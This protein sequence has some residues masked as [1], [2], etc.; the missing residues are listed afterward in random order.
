MVRKCT[1]YVRDP[2]KEPLLPH[3]L[4]K[5]PYQKIAMDILDFAGKS[6]LCV[7]DYYSKW[8]D[9]LP[10]QSKTAIDVIKKLKPLFSTHGIP[11]VVI[12]DNISFGTYEFRKFVENY[13]FTIR[14]TSPHYSR[15]NGLAERFVQIAKNIIRKEVNCLQLYWNT[16]RRLYQRLAWLLVNCY[17]IEE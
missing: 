13:D 11:N 6:Y 12:A 8:L 17:S 9:I 1:V 10:L 5:Y 4:L 15:S 2:L 3:E 14:I 16:A 7:V